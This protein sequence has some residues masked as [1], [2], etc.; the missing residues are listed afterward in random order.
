MPDKAL[1]WF[2]LGFIEDKHFDFHV[3]HSLFAFPMCVYSGGY[4]APGAGGYPA[5]GAGGYPQQQ[6]PAS[7]PPPASKPAPSTAQVTSQ[8]AQMKVNEE[9]GHGTIK[10]PATIDP[11]VD[12]GVLRKAMKGLGK[13]CVCVCVCIC[14][15]MCVCVC[16]C[17]Y[18]HCV[19]M[20]KSS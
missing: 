16:M 2:P 15:Y 12:A 8:M 4:P 1:R 14:M 10:A 20:C 5:P 18:I 17:V 6:P 19:F 7:Q 9:V 11:E 13:C 3:H